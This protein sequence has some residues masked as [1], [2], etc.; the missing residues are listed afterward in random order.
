MFSCVQFVHVSD[1][2]MYSH[3]DCD[4]LRVRLLS[5]STGLQDHYSVAGSDGNVNVSLIQPLLGR[6]VLEDTPTVDRP[7]SLI[8]TADS[9]RPT[10]CTADT[11]ME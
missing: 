4:S 11:V 5:T 9:G 2:C 7:A 10:A 8:I 1:A 3:T 6:A